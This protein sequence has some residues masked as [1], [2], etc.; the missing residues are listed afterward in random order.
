M[1]GDAYL[2]DESEWPVVRVVPPEG[3]I[4]DTEFARHLQRLTGFLERRQRMVFVVE[5]RLDAALSTEQ[6]DKIR[7]HE[8][9]HRALV[10]QYQAGMAIVVHSAFQRAMV[11]AVVWLVRSP[12]PT[13]VFSSLEG[14]L[15]W[16]ASLLGREAPQA[17]GAVHRAADAKTK[18]APELPRS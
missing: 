8:Q 9:Q 10:G 11:A 18:R 12:S 1:A 3:A 5:W 13:Q 6:R 16:A 17:S 4:S 7:S 15:T 2:Y 14:A